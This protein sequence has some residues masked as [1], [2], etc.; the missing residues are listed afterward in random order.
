MMD[1]STDLTCSRTESHA[2]N[3]CLLWRLPTEILDAIFEMYFE[4][5][6]D[7]DQRLFEWQ[8]SPHLNKLLFMLTSLPSRREGESLK[9]HEAGRTY[10]FRMSWE[11]RFPE[12]LTI[13]TDW[14]RIAMR[15]WLKTRASIRV[16]GA[17]I[18]LQDFSRL[19]PRFWSL[20]DR[21]D[22]DIGGNRYLETFKATINNSIKQVLHAFPHIETL[23]FI[24]T[25]DLIDELE[26]EWF[27]DD[28]GE[29]YRA[30]IEGEER[31]TPDAMFGNIPWVQTLIRHGQLEQVR[32]PPGSWCTTGYDSERE[33]SLWPK[34]P[35]AEM[36]GVL[37]YLE[38]Y[39]ND[40]LYEKAKLRKKAERTTAFEGDD[41]FA[42]LARLAIDD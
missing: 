25:D 41:G 19:K 16:S 1:T 35:S 36:C 28:L 42:H 11:D 32:F 40:K 34:Y 9:Y 14:C 23:E 15:S 27:P 2:T 22:L 5:L 24:E 37:E 17:N 30:D 3:K 7:P 18:E 6:Y 29:C 39:V 21:V 38:D 10:D 26:W 20:F 31:P 8:G 4:D 12:E 33:Y 13:S